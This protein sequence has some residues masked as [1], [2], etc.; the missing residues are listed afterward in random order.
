MD[1]TRLLEVL[2]RSRRLGFL[3]PGSVRVHVDHADGFAAG[4]ER[5]PTQFL[6]LGS[7][8]GV[9]GL[10]LARRWPASR[11]V[12]LEARER[13]CAFLREAAQDLHLAERVA[14]VWA[15]AEEAGHRDDLRGRFDVVVARG[16]G[17]PSVTAEC[18][19]PFLRLGGTLVV[20]EPPEDGAVAPSRWAP[21]GLACLGLRVGRSW[22]E[23]YRYQALDQVDPCPP[24]Y[25]RRPGMP[26]K[27][28]LF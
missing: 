28:P 10:V 21:A 13:R 8:G 24:Q 6:D 1:D 15:R 4:V 2:E 14:V 11:A 19:A 5:A 16:F 26:A 25:P 9:P 3:G 20:S 23:R 27:R 18:G 17:R 22:T 12:L 7:G